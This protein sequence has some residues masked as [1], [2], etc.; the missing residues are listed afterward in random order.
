MATIIVLFNLKDDVKR[1]DYEE[2]ARSTDLPVVR[3]LGSVD[4][5][6]VFRSSG[7]L[8]SDS[9]AP[10]QYVELIAINDGDAFSQDIGTDVMA[11]VAAQFQSFADNPQ[12]LMTD[13][14]S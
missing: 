10:F 1:E 3:N 14:L 2:W 9:P 5:Y 7:L 11:K 4:Q 12:F 13:K 8:G 6:D